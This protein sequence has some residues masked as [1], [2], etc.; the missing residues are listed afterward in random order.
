MKVIRAE[1]DRALVEFGGVKREVNIN[2]LDGV[3]PG[4]YIIVHAGFAIEKL[5]TGQAEDT[6][7]LINSLKK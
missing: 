1:G 5:D 6:L 2:F 4:D 7:R 3:A